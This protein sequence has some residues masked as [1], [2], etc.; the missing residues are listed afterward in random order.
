MKKAYLL[1]LIVAFFACKEEADVDYAL[2]EGNVL[3]NK[4][5]EVEI[6]G[7]DF[8]QSIA[9]NEDGTFSDTLKIENDGYYNFRIGRESSKLYLTKGSDIDLNI[10][11]QEF[12]E[13]IVYT[14]LG[15]EENNFLAQKYL[16]GEMLKGGDQEFYSLSADAFKDKAKEIK[17]TFL[18]LLSKDTSLSDSFEATEQK[19]IE[20]DY[21]LHLNNYKSFHRYYARVEEVNL[22]ENFLSDLDGFNYQDEETYKTFSN[23]RDL[24]K[25]HFSNRLVKLSEKY[26]GNYD[27]A[28]LE[29]TASIPKGY[30]KQE[31]LNEMA[32]AFLNPNENL[33]AMYATFT[34][35]VTNPEYL[36]SYKEKYDKLKTLAK[37]ASSPTFDFENYERG[38]TSLAD[39]KGKYVYIDV[40]ATW[41]GPCLREIPSL[42]KV[43]TEYHDKN[44]EFVS[45][46]IDRK[47]DYE[48][49]RKM[50]DDKEL[51]GIQLMAD[52]DWSSKFVKDYA[53][54]G[55][56]RFILIDTEGKIVTAD[57]PR[58]SDPELKALFEELNI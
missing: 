20:Y 11:V 38:T 24:V 41:C 22:P 4:A 58:P 40:W 46:S 2:F 36:K 47:K 53:I 21:L 32:F 12:D 45:I 55:I 1:G 3:N 16:K 48:A 29:L 54:E 5:K 31:Y 25:S 57:A 34:E 28:F 7:N 39:L 35:N 6:R 33:D 43:E 30:I 18:D 42:K 44:I 56:P 15:A 9:I 13:S 27:K 23:Y 17:N 50:V 51:G 49:W 52:N 10:D 14:G 8:E 26:E 37:G 19:S